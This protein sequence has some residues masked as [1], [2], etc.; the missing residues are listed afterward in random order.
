M[1]AL[2]TAKIKVQ[3]LASVRDEMKAVAH[4][5]ITTP[6]VAGRASVNSSGLA[7]GMG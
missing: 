3:T 4:G 7:S 5:E 1:K 6:T 2:A